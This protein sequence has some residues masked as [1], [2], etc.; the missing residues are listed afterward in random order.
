MITL[1]Q[2]VICASGE[3]KTNTSQSQSYIFR[4]PSTSTLSIHTL[5]FPIL[6]PPSLPSHPYSSSSSQISFSHTSNPLTLRIQFY[7]LSLLTR[8]SPIHYP[9]SSLSPLNSYTSMPSFLHS[10]PFFRRR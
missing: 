3:L 2:T 6:H 5:F 10:A 4:F 9:R 7:M 1:S 8:C